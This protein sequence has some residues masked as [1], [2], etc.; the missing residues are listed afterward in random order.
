[1]FLISPFSRCGLLQVQVCLFIVSLLC[2][3]E[4]IANSGAGVEDTSPAPS[5]DVAAQQTTIIDGSGGNGGD[6]NADKQ[7]K[8][9]AKR[10]SLRVNYS[11][12]FFIQWIMLYLYRFRR[13]TKKV[14]PDRSNNDGWTVTDRA[15]V[16][17]GPTMKAGHRRNKKKW[18]HFLKN[19]FVLHLLIHTLWGIYARTRQ[20]TVQVWS[21]CVYCV[22]IININN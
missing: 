14:S 20:D 3:H 16:E 9:R 5:G 8:Q 22:L 1:M 6:N 13:R 17:N 7:P 19:H 2:H 18:I 11:I 10:A 21:I 4:A 12:R 15:G